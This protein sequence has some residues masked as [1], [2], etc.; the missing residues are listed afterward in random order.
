VASIKRFFII[1]RWELAIEYIIELLRISDD[2]IEFQ[3]LLL[4]LETPLLLESLELVAI[5]R[6]DSSEGILH[7]GG[8]CG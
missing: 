4:R 8:A 3:H 5:L 7:F 6:F 2:K 1:L